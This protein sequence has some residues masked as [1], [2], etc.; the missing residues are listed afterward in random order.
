[1]SK[2][3]VL[4]NR[5]G[6]SEGNTAAVFT[7]HRGYSL[8]PMGHKQ[9]ELTA[10]YLQENFSVDAVYCSDLPRAF[11]TA[12]HIALKY[13]L[14]IV[15]DASLRELFGGQWENR[16]F[17][18]LPRDFPEDFAVW[19][20]DTIHSR[21]TDGESVLELTERAV[22]GIQKIAEKH[23]GQTVV[24]VSHA[25]PIRTTLWKV[26]GQ[27]EQAF[28]TTGFGCNCAVSELTF[29]NGALSIVAANYT[30]HLQGCKTQLP[31]NI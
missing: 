13:D 12:E 24:M 1:M 19:Q 6:E 28:Q 30:D 20:E 26:S 9:A 18:E 3:T 14:P 7:G 10:E 31:S 17:S 4:L 25:T 2:T 21:C 15:T 16:K 5:H 23:P 27:S 11:Q 29:E 22:E 8:T